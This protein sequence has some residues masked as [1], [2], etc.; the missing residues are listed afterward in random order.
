VSAGTVAD[1]ETGFAM[2]GV[3][4]NRD[5]VAAR[6]P[7][8]SVARRLVLMLPRLLDGA[9][10]AVEILAPAATDLGGRADPTAVTT[11]T[12]ATIADGMVGPGAGGAAGGCAGLDSSSE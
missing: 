11:G 12:G 8:L 9:E 7:E 4:L 6:S 3:E 5:S 10:G 1:K 2:L